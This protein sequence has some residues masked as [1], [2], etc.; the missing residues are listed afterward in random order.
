MGNCL[1]QPPMLFRLQRALLGAGAW[2]GRLE[3]HIAVLVSGW[4]SLPLLI[5]KSIHR[6]AVSYREKPFSRMFNTLASVQRFAEFQEA[7][8]ALILGYFWLEP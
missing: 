3:P 8:L 6:Q 7:L 2:I 5:P 4:R 1:I